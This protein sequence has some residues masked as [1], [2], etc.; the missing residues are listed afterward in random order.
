MMML[1]H[2]DRRLAFL[3]GVLFFLALL[4]DLLSL[5]GSGHLRFVSMLVLC[6]LGSLPLLFGGGRNR[7]L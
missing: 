7:F 3:L 4:L 6:L 1:G 5:D 2:D